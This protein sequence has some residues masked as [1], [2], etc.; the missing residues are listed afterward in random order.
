VREVIQPVETVNV[1]AGNLNLTDAL[2]H[3]NNTYFQRVGG[4]VGF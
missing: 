4:Q 1:G 2:A 3:S